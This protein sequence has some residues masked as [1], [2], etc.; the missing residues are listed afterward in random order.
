MASSYLTNGEGSN[1]LAKTHMTLENPPFE[2]VFPI[3]HGDFPM[4]C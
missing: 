1:T 3:D 4:S 2:D